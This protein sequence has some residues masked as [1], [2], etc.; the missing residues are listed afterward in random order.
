ME[1]R[2]QHPPGSRRVRLAGRSRISQGRRANAASL[3]RRPLVQRMSGLVATERNQAR[4]GRA[5]VRDERLAEEIV[6]SG[7]P[8]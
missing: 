6:F 3:D 7:A 8:A 4:T 2:V 1:S 5:E